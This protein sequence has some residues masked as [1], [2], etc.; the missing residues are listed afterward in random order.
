MDILGYLEYAVG[1]I[2]LSV[3]EVLVK[4]L[5]TSPFTAYMH[6]FSESQ[7][8]KYINY[9]V[10]IDVCV[11]IMETW[12]VCVALWYAYGFVR[13]IMQWVSGYGVGGLTLSK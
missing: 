9:F 7:Y 13:D 10:P 6:Y 8:L 11:A 2:L 1:S 12:L 4:I 3:V 5:P